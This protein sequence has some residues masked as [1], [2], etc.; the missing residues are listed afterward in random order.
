MCLLFSCL[1]SGIYIYIDCIYILYI[2]I[3][4]LYIYIYVQCVCVFIFVLHICLDLCNY[5]ARTPSCPGFD[6]KDRKWD[7]ER[8]LLGAAGALGPHTWCGL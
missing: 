7:P 1:F 6:P 4:T 3:Y 2:Y 5:I 8:L